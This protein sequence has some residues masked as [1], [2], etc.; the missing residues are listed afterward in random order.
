MNE[1]GEDRRQTMRMLDRI[2]FFHVPIEP[3]KYET[4]QQDF[5]KGIPPYQREELQDIRLHIGAESALARLR[6]RDEDLADFLFHLDTKINTLL[7]EVRG[8]HS[9]L[10]RLVLETVS[11]GAGGMAFFS[12][13]ALAIGAYLELHLVLEPYHLYIYCLGE[14]VNCDQKGG[15]GEKPYRISVK[16]TLITEEDREKLVQHLFKLQSMALR[17]KRQWE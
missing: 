3:K 8:G 10:D 4:V 14:V 7:K 11:V 17:Q 1:Q 13:T 12:E 6:N 2:K 5:E 16:F 15:S 9:P